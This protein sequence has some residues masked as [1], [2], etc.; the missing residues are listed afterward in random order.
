MKEKW[1]SA[2]LDI[3]RNFSSVVVVMNLWRRH[4]LGII[5]AHG[6][7]AQMEVLHFG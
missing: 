5:A 7:R 3:P 4:L 1:L 6:G 2:L